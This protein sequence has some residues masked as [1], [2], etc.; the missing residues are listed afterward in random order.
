VDV[1]DRRI[2]AKFE[3]EHL[4]VSGQCMDLSAGGQPP[5]GLQLLL[6][7]KHQVVFISNSSMRY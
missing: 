6:G 5:R 2:Y 4:V 1:S 7:S 3:L